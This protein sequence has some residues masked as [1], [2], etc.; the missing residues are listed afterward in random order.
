MQF[1]GVC[2][3]VSVVGGDHERPGIRYGTAHLGEALIG[4]GQNGGYPFTVRIKGGA[5][6]LAVTS[7]VNPSPR[8]AAISSPAEVRH[9]ICPEYA[10]KITGRTTWSLR[11][12][13]YP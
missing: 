12:G 11:A 10:M 9:R 6:R 2:F 13:P 4:S 7:L 1:F 3:S 8:F 5:P